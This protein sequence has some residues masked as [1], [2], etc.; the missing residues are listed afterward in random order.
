ML[1]A[2]I[3]VPRGFAAKNA[4]K[5]ARRRLHQRMAAIIMHIRSARIAAVMAMCVMAYMVTYSTTRGFRFFC[6]P[7]RGPLPYFQ[8]RNAAHRTSGT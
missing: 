3:V 5:G 7:S 1:S 4:G 6:G 8:V 2:G